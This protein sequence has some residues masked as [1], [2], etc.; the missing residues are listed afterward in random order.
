MDQHLSWKLQVENVCSKLRL[1]LDKFIHLKFVA[2]RATMYTIYHTLVESILSYGLSSY[3]RTFSS[4]LEDIK[5]LQIRFLKLLVDKKVKENCQ[6]NYINLFHVCK[7]LPVHEKVKLLI[8]L[9]EYRKLDF[10]KT[11]TH[12]HITRAVSKNKYDVPRTINYYGQ[13]T[14]A[15]LVPKICN[16]L[17]SV[18]EDEL[19]K[20][21][22]KRK[23]QQLLLSKVH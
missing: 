14:K 18:K 13:R 23:I 4:Y 17:L 1:A 8:A 6:K 11:L 5:Q 7:V 15:Y 9:E 20:Y 2:D 3:G 21:A 22:F 19:S 10:K 12:S 16:E